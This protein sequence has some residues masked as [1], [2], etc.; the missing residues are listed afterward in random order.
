MKEPRSKMTF[1]DDAIH[2]FVY[3]AFGPTDDQ[4]EATSGLYIEVSFGRVQADEW[5]A[6]AGYVEDP[7][8]EDAWTKQSIYMDADEL[9]NP[10]APWREGYSGDQGWDFDTV[11]AM[12]PE[13]QKQAIIAVAIAAIGYG[14]GS[15]ETVDDLWE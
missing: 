12:D 9:L 13:A 10:K 5:T 2:D 8:L 15:E 4:D 6:L 14:A 1:D 11:A 3:E 7:E